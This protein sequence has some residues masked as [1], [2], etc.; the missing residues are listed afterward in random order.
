MITPQ[1]KAQ[2]VSWSIET[3]SDIQTQRNYTTKYA[4]QAL[5]HVSRF[6]IGISSLWKQEH[7][8]INQAVEGQELLK[9]ASSVFISHLV[10]VQESPS[11]LL[12]LSC[13]YLNQQFIKF[14][15]IS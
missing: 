2:C 13:K 11:V 3:K 7:C 6:T 12:P 1:E 4:K 14:S 5:Q 8:Y 15:I 9:K 10:V